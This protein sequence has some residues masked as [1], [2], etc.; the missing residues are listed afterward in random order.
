MEEQRESP[1]PRTTAPLSLSKTF[2]THLGHLQWHA[3]YYTMP[4][5]FGTLKSWGYFLWSLRGVLNIS[6]LPLRRDKKALTQL[7]TFE[8]K[9]STLF[10]YQ[11]VLT[12]QWL[13]GP[14]SKSLQIINAGEGVQKRESSYTVGGKVNLCSYYRKQY[15]SLKKLKISI[16]LLYNQATP[17][18][19]IYPAKT[20]IWKHTCPPL[21][22]AAPLTIAKTRKQP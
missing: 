16:E 3:S 10:T 17:F 8:C 1:P 19:G 18:P 2:L 12:S 13:E 4:L 14:S 21:L 20:V 9:T 6:L 15:G 11:K 5:D 7:F 22:T